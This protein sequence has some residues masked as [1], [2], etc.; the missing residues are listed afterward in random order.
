MGQL[1]S[2]SVNSSS[3][4]ESIKWENLDFHVLSHYHRLRCS[5]CCKFKQKSF[6]LFK[7]LPECFGFINYALL[8][9]IISHQTNTN[10][11]FVKKKKNFFSKKKKKKKKKKK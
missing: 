8:I 9:M 2:T 1:L 10:V 4:L 11:V 6:V 3:D 7:V 5:M